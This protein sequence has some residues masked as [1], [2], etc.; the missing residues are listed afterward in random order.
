MSIGDGYLFSAAGPH[1]QPI[2]THDEPKP[3][4]SYIGII[5]MAILGSKERKLVLSDIYQWILDNYPYFRRRGPGWR[6]S[7][8]H[9]L[10]LNDCFVKA[11]RSANGKGHYWAIHPANV[12]DFE[13]GDFRRRRAQR[14]VRR[15]MG[16]TVADD[17]DDSP[18]PSPSTPAAV[19]SQFRRPEE[20]PGFREKQEFREEPGFREK[21]AYSSDPPMELRVDHTGAV[22]MIP[23]VALVRRPVTT[24]SR[25]RLFDVDS[26]LAPDVDKQAD[27][28][29][30]IWAP[31][32]PEIDSTT[33]QLRRRDDDDDCRVAFPVR[34]RKQRR[35]ALSPEVDDVDLVVARRRPITAAVR[36]DDVTTTSGGLAGK[37][38][39]AADDEIDVVTSPNSLP[40][41]RSGDGDETGSG[42]VQSRRSVD[43][44][45]TSGEA[46]SGARAA[47]PDVARF[48]LRHASLASTRLAK[49]L[50]PLPL[51]AY[52]VTSGINGDVGLAR[53]VG[54]GRGEGHGRVQGHDWDTAEGRCLNLVQ[55]EGRVRGRNQGQ[56]QGRGEG[57]RICDVTDE[58]SES[59]SP[60]RDETIVIAPVNAL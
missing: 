44:V 49:A 20:E 27:E 19:W 15:A 39:T 8:R 17:E 16:L 50:F 45:T 14:K 2:T 56:C 41:R 3:N 53:N 13:R 60:I 36:D 12:E 47:D 57:Q 22:G 18:V 11:G 28:Q 5:S 32:R 46:A 37:P 58:S 31:H 34:D 23:P 52:H 33:V 6:N 29:P 4:Y 43:V 7:I 30:E 59:V 54:Q 24:V 9:N 26:L 51:A 42:F 1:Q 38:A 25:K 48:W 10:S 21:S 40:G 55:G 35:A